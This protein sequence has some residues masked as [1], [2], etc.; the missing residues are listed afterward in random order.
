MPTTQFE[1]NDPAASPSSLMDCSSEAIIMGLNTLSSKWPLLPA[2]DTPTWLPMT[3]RAAAA[4]GQQDNRRTT[5]KQ[6]Q[7][8]DP[9]ANLMQL[10]AMFMIG[11]E[12]VAAFLLCITRLASAFTWAQSSTAYLCSHHCECFTLRGVDLA[13]HDGAAWLVLRQQQL[14]KTTPAAPHAR[15]HVYSTAHSR[16]RERQAHA[17]TQTHAVSLSFALHDPVCVCVCGAEGGGRA[18]AAAT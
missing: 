4:T 9:S 2:T 16:D 14:P 3:C 7:E 11:I 6:Q 10:H 1:E 8:E 12:G 13:W 5:T 18:T 17:N 15:T